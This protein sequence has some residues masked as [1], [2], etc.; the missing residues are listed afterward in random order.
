MYIVRILNHITLIPVSDYCS[1]SPTINAQH[2]TS[3]YQSHIIML[4][5]EA[6]WL[7]GCQSDMLL[8]WLSV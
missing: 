1:R 7:C 3:S 4:G 2:S 5:F 6:L 8:V